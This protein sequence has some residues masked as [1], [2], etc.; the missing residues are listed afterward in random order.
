VTKPAKSVHR[1]SFY[2]ITIASMT[3]YRIEA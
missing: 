3:L 2:T 1:V